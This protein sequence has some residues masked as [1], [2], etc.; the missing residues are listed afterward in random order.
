MYRKPM[1]TQMAQK[2]PSHCS[3][4]TDAIYMTN[5]WVMQ[6]ATCNVYLTY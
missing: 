2:G 4:L 5:T 1:L 3:I 6:L